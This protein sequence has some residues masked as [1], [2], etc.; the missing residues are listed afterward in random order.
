MQVCLLRTDAQILDA[1]LAVRPRALVGLSTALLSLLAAWV[2]YNITGRIEGL[3]GAVIVVRL[4]AMAALSRLVRD[5]V[6][7]ARSGTPLALLLALV[8][9]GCWLAAHAGNDVQPVARGVLSIAVLTAALGLIWLCMTP[10]I[11]LGALRPKGDG[12]RS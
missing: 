5:Q 9:A 7:D 1:A 12:A 8:L 6:P 2:G 4:P 10:G 11:G 3:L